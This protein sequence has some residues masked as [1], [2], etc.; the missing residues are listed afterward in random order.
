MVTFDLA[1]PMRN[2]QPEDYPVSPFVCVTVKDEGGPI[3]ES[4]LLATEGEIDN[5]FN[6]I[7]FELKLLPKDVDR[8]RE[9]AKHELAV[10]QARM[11]GHALADSRPAL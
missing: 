11:L 10:Q 1:S 2:W 5:F 4:A 3:L 8:S 9:E 7:I 6:R